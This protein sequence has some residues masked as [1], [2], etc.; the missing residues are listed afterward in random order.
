MKISL[1]PSKHPS[2]EKKQQHSYLPACTSDFPA[3]GA[4]SMFILGNCGDTGLGWNQGASITGY[5]GTQ[6][7]SLEDMKVWAA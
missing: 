3:V 7:P 2:R 5:C 4:R 6:V 1:G